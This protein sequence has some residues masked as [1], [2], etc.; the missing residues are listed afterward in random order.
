[1]SQLGRRTV[2]VYVVSAGVLLVSFTAAWLTVDIE[3]RLLP[4]EAA[5]RRMGASEHLLNSLAVGE[6]RNHIV[7]EI[8][9]SFGVIT[10]A[11]HPSNDEEA[12]TA[13]EIIDHL[14]SILGIKE[15]T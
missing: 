13:A 5:L 11:E 15:L 6:R 4:F 2:K 3:S 9:K 12:V 14:R 1:M 7:D 8:Y 10:G